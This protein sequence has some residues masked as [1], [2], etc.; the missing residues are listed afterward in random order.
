MAPTL[1]SQKANTPPPSTEPSGTSPASP[2]PS[3]APA[4]DT[5]AP[6]L[7]S[8]SDSDSELAL[9]PISTAYTHQK[10]AYTK[11]KMSSANTAVEHPITKHC[12]ILTAGDVTPKSLIDLEDAHNEYFIA[13]DIVDADKVK[14]ILGGFKCVH[15]R[16]WIASER[17]RILLLP[18]ADFMKELRANYL[19][20]DWEETVRAQILGMKMGKSDKFWDWCQEMR[21]INIIL[22]GTPS[23]LSDI[24][25]RNQLEAA[26]EPSLLNYCF[27]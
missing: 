23:H 3:T 4:A 7:S 16:N 24:A 8:D 2:A 9:L 14:K 13:K 21:A 22:R 12:P 1:R 15:I 6:Q 19:P 20:P 25:L 18:Y 11:P 5:V 26:L 17:A 10:P 27:R